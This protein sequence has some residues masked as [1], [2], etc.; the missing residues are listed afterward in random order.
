MP[1]IATRPGV[2]AALPEEPTRPLPWRSLAIAAGG[3]AILAAVIISASALYQSG[4]L[5][6]RHIKV[7]GAQVVDARLAADATQLTGQSLLHLDT[8]SAAVRV[9]ELP[10]VASVRVN[11]DWPRGVVIDITELQGWGY[12]QS[13]TGWAVIDAQGNVLEKARPPAP[14]A[15]TIHEAGAGRLIGPGGSIDRDTVELVARLLRD[16]S[17]LRLGIQPQRFEFDRS[18]GL[19]VRVNGGPSAVFGDSHDYE[20]KVAAWGATNERINAEGM[21]VTEI[22]LRFGKELVVR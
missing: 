22:D 15:P 8:A 6:V 9:A 1:R 2:V 14:N 13:S 4:A 12:W 10:G 7:I 11:R 17:F 16:G 3:C 20:F 18:R 21:Q 5:R 19:V